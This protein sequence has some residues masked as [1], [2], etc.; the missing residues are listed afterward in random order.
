MKQRRRLSPRKIFRIRKKEKDP[1]V[2]DRLLLV[3]LVERDGMSM[4]GAARH[5]GAAPSWGVKWYNRYQDEGRK[6]L[7]T[8][9]RSG[10]PPKVPKET[11]EG[12]KKQAIE[13]VYVTAEGI[14]ASIEQASKVRHAIS[15]V[16]A[17]IRGWGFTRKVPV[18]RHVR[19]AN[20]WKI[21]WFRRKIRPRIE[22]MRHEG[23]TIGVQDESIFIADARPRKG[24]Y[25]PKGVRAVYTYTGSHSKT[26]VFGMI[27]TDGRGLFKQYDK[28]TKEEFVDFLKAAHEEFGKILMILDG[29]P[30]HRAADVK[31]ALK[32][33]NGEV[34]LEF[35]PP[36][37]PDLS[38]IEE[39]WRQMKHAVLDT[40]YVKLS[41][42]CRDI[43]D[44][45]KSSMPKLDVE[46]YLYRA[47]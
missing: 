21:G 17:L 30:Q 36:G 40:A 45:I 23:Y 9:P 27:T 47:L 14:L 33:M 13:K 16:R 37:C 20:R 2:R 10:R 8:R 41:K 24:V 35:L 19:R 32:E 38:A 1:A 44:W 46:K 3:I 42:M 31:K 11:M 34:E 25:T 28:S 7:Q 29:A 26:A 18:G 6:G 12:I 15:Y 5:L 39:L 22:E 4:S 43:D